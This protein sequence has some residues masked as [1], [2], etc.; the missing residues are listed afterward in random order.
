MYEFSLTQVSELAVRRFTIYRLPFTDL[1]QNGSNL[2]MNALLV[3]V[4][5]IVVI[6]VAFAVMYNKLISL[7]NLAKNAWADVDVY[8][9]RRA[10]LI[11]NLVAAVKGYSAY[12]ASTLEKVVAARTTAA[13]APSIPQRADAEGN[14]SQGITKIF[15]LAEAYPDLKANQSFL[16]LQKQLAEAE[17]SIADARQYYNAVVRDFNTAREAF[18]SNIVAGMMALKPLDF[19]E[20]E[21]AAE[22]QAPS[23]AM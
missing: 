19:F 13:S 1:S 16:D 17:K 10:Q 14:L 15:A 6:L 8:L 3:L 9:K 11:P 7:R 2:Q 20:V 4:I 21:T 12:E 18:P 5:L 22:R 23:A